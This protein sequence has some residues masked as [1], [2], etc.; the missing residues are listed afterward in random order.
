MPHD[1]HI[2]PGAFGDEPKTVPLVVYDKD[3]TRRVVGEA[4][5][6]PNDRGIHI[7]G[8]ITDPEMKKFVEE[9]GGFGALLKS[10]FEE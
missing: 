10:K 7:S 9:L 2:A 5:V 8:N 6:T 1:E 4:T 3:G